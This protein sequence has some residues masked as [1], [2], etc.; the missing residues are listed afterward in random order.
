MDRKFSPQGCARRLLGSFVRFLRCW[1]GSSS[2]HPNPPPP[3]GGG[4]GG[5]GR[6]R[7]GL[8]LL[9][10]RTL[11]D[12]SAL[13][14]QFR[15]GVTANQ[16]LLDAL[17]QSA[18]AVVSN[19]GIPDLVRFRGARADLDR[20]WSQFGPLDEVVYA[21]Y[22]GTARIAQ[23]PNDPRFLDGTLWGQSGTNGIKAPQA[24]D[25]TT[26]STKVAVAVIDTGIDYKH[27]DLY[28]NIWLNQGEI[29][30]SVKAAIQANPNWDVDGDGLITF[31]DLNNSINQGS[32]KIMDLD[33][34]RRI[35]G[36]DV[37]FPVAQGGWADNMDS[38][39]NGYKD[40]L[41]GWNFVTNTNNPLDDQSHGT[42]VAGTIGAEGNN[43]VGVVGVNWK[44]QLAALKIMDSTGTGSDADGAAA[45]RY[46]ANNGILISNN[47]WGS[48]EFNTTLYNAISYANSKGHLFVAAAGNDAANSDTNPGYP[49]AFNLSNIVA[50]AA[51]TSGG[52]LASFSNWGPTT[53]DLA[54]PG[55][56]IY[57]TVPGGGYGYKSGTSMATPHVAGTA[58]LVKAR[59]PNLTVAELKD[60]LL[61]RVT[62]RSSLTGLLVTGG[63]V[64]AAEAV[65]D[66]PEI[67]VLDGTTDLPDNTGTAT[68]G[69]TLPDIGLTRTFT[70]ANLGTQPL[71]L[72][73]IS[74]PSGFSVAADFGTSSVAP[75]AST[76][77][78]VKLQ[79]STLGSYSGQVSFAT[80]DAD[81]DPF[82]FTV[83]GT[84][85]DRAILD[86]GEAGFSTVGS[87]TLFI[88]QG[89][90]NDVTYSAAGSGAS[91]ASW[92][93]TVTPGQYRV[94]ATWST[95]PNRATDAP[96]TIL[97][98]GSALATVRVNQELTPND[99][100]ADG[101]A[102]EELGT[103]TI[104]GTSLV[105][106][107]SDAANEY[108]I[109]D[110]IRIQR[111]SGL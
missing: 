58:A 86:D 102:W 3:V 9:E 78:Q 15:P 7:P 94:W 35:T 67:Q 28:R 32:G 30:A 104:T 48:D 95:H 96:Y 45:V 43:G 98:G 56:N 53:V 14:V 70:V 88:G 76:T 40:D 101:T 74:V 72:G 84:V 22:E 100:Q 57:S 65:K 107:L 12:A 25:T 29:P 109:A 103:F 8:E 66:G 5:G 16:P 44:V 36:A 21:E 46:A 1:S 42:H 110:A 97:D 10:D 111:L 41:I 68:I 59:S 82:N 20:L 23:S 34:D 75:G 19:P 108:V 85:S 79:A 4:Q 50:V 61:S 18:H 33:G 83:T 64:N 11:L 106:R 55:V 87:W 24:W 47:S 90:G 27:V 37:L 81:E 51:T 26:G 62:P 69:T 17:A 49:A 80:N 77:F 105:V 93:F 60:R 31:W 52:N 73:T 91:V 63:L 54:A 2:P 92:A 38:D 71:T 89:L 99:L 6:Q 39:G 13:L